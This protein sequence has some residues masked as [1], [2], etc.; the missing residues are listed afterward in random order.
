MYVFDLAWIPLVND[1]TMHKQAAALLTNIW[2]TSNTAGKLLWQAQV[3][4]D[5]VEAKAVWQL[6]AEEE[7]LRTAE[8]QKEKDN[9]C[10]E[11]KKNQ[12]KFFPIPN[13][14]IPQRAPVITTQ[15]AMWHMDKGECIPL[16]YYT[17]KGLE[18]TLITYTS[19][20]NDTLTLL[21]HP[22]GS[23]SLIPAS[24]SKESKMSSLIRT[25]SGRTSVLPPPGGLKVWGGPI[26]HTITYR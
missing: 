12:S 7:A 9:L 20:D 2:N 21:H 13:Q 22:D 10:Q 6:K 15:S 3:D 18:N 8:V 19:I 4:T 14:P 17:I 25:S 16:W 26:G 23:T 1:N 11:C 24:S 5:E